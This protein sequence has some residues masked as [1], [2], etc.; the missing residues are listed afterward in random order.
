MLNEI[1]CTCTGKVQ[2]DGVAGSDMIVCC[3][4]YPHQPHQEAIED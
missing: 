1:F 3:P 2:R 4:Y